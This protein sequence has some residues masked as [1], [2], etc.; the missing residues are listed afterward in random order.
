MRVNATPRLFGGFFVRCHP[1][2]V[3]F[4]VKPRVRE[5]F[6]QNL[7]HKGITS[8]IRSSRGCAL[9]PCRCVGFTMCRRVETT[10]E[11]EQYRL[12]RSGQKTRDAILVLGWGVGA[13][14][15]GFNVHHA[16]MPPFRKKTRRNNTR[17]LPRVPPPPPPPASP[18]PPP[19]PSP[20]SFLLSLFIA[21]LWFLGSCLSQ[22]NPTR[23][24]RG[25]PPL[26]DCRRYS[27]APAFQS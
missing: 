25:G 14:R 2:N 1:V 15:A 3:P 22:K 11:P 7:P 27:K 5:D 26:P 18:A 13:M 6:D 17:Q 10:A 23:S 21:L 12:P 4:Q 16:P 24:S 9:T 8:R 20:S 19:P